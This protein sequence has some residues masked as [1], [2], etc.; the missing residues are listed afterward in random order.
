MSSAA[1][2]PDPLI[3]DRG[4]PLPAGAQSHRAIGPFDAESIPAGLFRLHRLKAGAW[5]IVTI[6]A[7]GIRFVWDDAEGGARDLTAPASIL[8]PPEVPHHL[9]K[10]GSVELAIAFWS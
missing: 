10:A 9:E 7:G 1:A 2:P 4:P 3:A 5:G 6:R 8:V